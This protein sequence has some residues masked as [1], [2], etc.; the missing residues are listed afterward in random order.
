MGWAYSPIVQLSENPWAEFMPFLGFEREIRQIVRMSNAIKSGNAR[1]RKAVR[2][3]S[4]LPTVQAD[5]K[6]VQLA[7][8]VFAPTGKAGVR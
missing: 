8:T 6:C 4:R 5:L 1:I 7:V 2:A 3:R